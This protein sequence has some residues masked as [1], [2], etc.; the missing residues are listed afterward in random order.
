MDLYNTSA[1]L[2]S[3]VGCILWGAHCGYPPFGE[4]T[5]NVARAVEKGWGVGVTVHL[6]SSLAQRLQQAFTK[7]LEDV[8]FGERAAQMSSL[9]QAHRWT[10]AEVAAGK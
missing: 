4:Q 7:V 8:S 10:A 2:L 3:H 6:L 5:D 1:C 9:M